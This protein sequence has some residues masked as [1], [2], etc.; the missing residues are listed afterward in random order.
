MGALY[1]LSFA[2]WNFA[3]FQIFAWILAIGIAH[4]THSVRHTFIF[5]MAFQTAIGLGAFP[6]IVYASSRYGDLPYFVAVLIWI[7]FS[8]T[9]QLHIPLYFLAR[10]YWVRHFSSWS[11]PVL[12]AL[13]FTGLDQLNPKLFSDTPGQAFA[14]WKYFKQIAEWGGPSLLTFIAIAFAESCHLLVLHFRN[15]VTL[16][17][18]KLIQTTSLAVILIL[19][20]I[21]YGAWRVQNIIEAKTALQSQVFK[22]GMAQ[23]NIGDFVKLASERGNFSA[24]EQV[25]QTYTELSRY[26]FAN[27]KVD[28]VVW[29]ETAYPTLFGRGRTTIERNM[30]IQIEQLSQNHSGTLIFG[31]YDRNEKGEDFNSL[32]FLKPK[33]SS[34]QVYHKSIL[35]QFGETLPG[36]KLFPKV[37]ELF[38]MMGFFGSGPGPEVFTLGNANGDSF[39]AAASICYEGIDVLFNKRASEM[40]ADFFLNVTNDSWFGA[41]AEPELHLALT[42]FR[43]IENRIPFARA[44]NTGYTVLIDELGEVVQSTALF[45]K[46]SLTASLQ[47]KID[48]FRVPLWFYEGWF[49]FVKSFS[50]IMLFALMLSKRLK[51]RHS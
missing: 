46:T 7:L 11:H 1:V 10:K 32:F 20:P 35:L 25:I 16:S 45:E 38:P 42:T 26:L 36:F 50:L 14:S 28:A 19:G 39:K 15:S 2:P 23:G 8:L 37:K 34:P 41:F 31:G 33:T 51:V 9:S 3:I 17:R 40:G 18:V 6:W 30:E 44:T 22:L 24:S 29:P 47:Q 27:E 5:S 12:L 49:I 13:F 48:T 21:F 43:S 4:S